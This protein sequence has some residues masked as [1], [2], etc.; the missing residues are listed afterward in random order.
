MWNT[1]FCIV[2]DF[3]H[4]AW[5]R[6]VACTGWGGRWLRDLVPGPLGTAW[7][8]APLAMGSALLGESSLVT[9]IE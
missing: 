3:A 9:L 4:V 8:L 5:L 7:L 2:V 6:V 1:S